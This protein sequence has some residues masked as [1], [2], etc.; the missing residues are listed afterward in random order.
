M[1]DNFYL[2]VKSLMAPL[3]ELLEP[4]T[5]LTS[6]FFPRAETY[7]TE[8]VSV[9]IVRGERRTAAYVK[10]LAEGQIMARTGYVTREYTPPQLK[11]KIPTTSADM[12]IRMPGENVFDPISPEQRAAQLL[13]K[14]QKTLVDAIQ[15]A[16]EIQASQAL[17]T[18]TVTVWDD[19]GNALDS[20]S[21][22]RDAS[23]IQNYAAVSGEGFAFDA[24]GSDPIQFIREKKLAVSKL[25]GI[26]P[27]EM[28]LGQDALN[29]FLAN[30]EVRRQLDLWRFSL[31]AVEADFR[32]QD[33]GVITYGFIEGVYI[34]SYAEWY[35]TPGTETGSTQVAMVP[36]KKVLL[37]SSKAQTQVAY[38]ANV[39]E[40][41]IFRNQYAPYQYTSKDPNVQWIQIYSRPLVIPNQTDAFYVGEVVA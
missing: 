33:M 35:K 4:R 16:V 29:A 25:C 19:E 41:R 30:E 14:D 2:N 13:A 12:F 31:G 5:F 26:V 6:K 23:L 7:P 21:F 36:S 22:G 34:R 39:L 40:G 10:P 27:D 17:F 18:D 38:G 32:L 28:L 9:D 11:P 3:M 37:G 15:R 20:I 8:T 24:S 1:A